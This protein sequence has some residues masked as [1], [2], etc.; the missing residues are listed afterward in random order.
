MNNQL[1]LVLVGTL[2][3]PPFGGVKFQSLEQRTQVLLGERGARPPSA[4]PAGR[5]KQGGSKGCAA[6]P[7]QPDVAHRICWLLPS[8]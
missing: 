2:G 4:D 7:R 8:R 3:N 1:S 5:G 6:P